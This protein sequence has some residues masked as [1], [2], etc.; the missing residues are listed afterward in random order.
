V[1]D[2]SRTYGYSLTAASERTDEARAAK[3]VK[4]RDQ[5]ASGELVI[6]EMSPE[7]RKRWPALPK[8]RK[9]SDKATSDYVHLNE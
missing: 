7:E 5:I 4:L 6:R 2:P 8:R 3:L 9:S 1:T